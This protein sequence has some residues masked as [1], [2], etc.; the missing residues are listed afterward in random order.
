MLHNARRSGLTLALLLLALSTPAPALFAATDG[1]DPGLW[2]QTKQKVNAGW[3]ASK[4]GAA[5][6]ANWTKETSKKSWEATKSG[7]TKATNWTSEKT[8]AGWQATKQAAARDETE[9][10]DSVWE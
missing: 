7:T 2:E 8:K 4:E 9:Q 6:A 1:T 10:T 5:K 3:E